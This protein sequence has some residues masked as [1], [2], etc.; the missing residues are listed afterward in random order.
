MKSFKFTIKKKIKDRLGRAG[1]IETPH[2]T[3]ETPAFAVVGT[4]G[5]VKSL[6]IEDLKVTEAQVFLANTYHLYLQPGSKLV[7]EA[8]G[9]HA[10]TGWNGPM[11]TDS[12]GFQ[13]FSLGA[14]YGK[15]ITKF[16]K[17][18]DAK[19]LPEGKKEE[20][21]VGPKIAQIDADGVS[22]RSHI[23]GSLHYFTPE[24]SIEIQHDLGADIIFAFDECTSPT[25]SLHYQKEALER[26]HR[27]AKRCLKFHKENS[28]GTQALFGVVQGGR[29]EDLRRESAQ[30]FGELDFDGYGIGGSF[31][32]EDIAT[33]VRWVNETLPPEKPRHMLGIGEPLDIFAGV[34]NG[35]DLFDCVAPTRN[36]R[37]GTLYTKDG[38]INILNAR[39]TN[40]FTPLESDCEC[41]TCKNFT[42]AYISHLFRA[43]EM[44]AATLASIHNVYFLNKLMKD[45]REAIYED[46]F[47]ELKQQFISRYYEK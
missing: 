26:T 6:T 22:F 17:G 8:G 19:L 7:K 36:G 34:E 35:C 39:F 2:G 45:I 12:G 29:F 20:E 37:T 9:L 44:L 38:K 33:S 24:K 3:I 46:R 28:N 14:A 5:T 1:F 47:D 23:D 27:W 43:K 32:K 13:V 15:N 4:K 30:F 21:E 25:E 11:I 41:Y 31:I 18:E 42:K 10:F 16:V 40:D